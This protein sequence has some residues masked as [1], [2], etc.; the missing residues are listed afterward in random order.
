[1]NCKDNKAGLSFY[2]TRW[3]W[4]FIKIDIWFSIEDLTFIKTFASGILVPKTYKWPL[5]AKNYLEPHTSLVS[6]AHKAWLE[7]YA[8][9]FVNDFPLSFNYSYNPVVESLNYIDNGDFSIDGM[10][11]NFPMTQS[12]SIG[13]LSLF[14]S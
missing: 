6:N 7:V 2:G 11:S 9:D 12:E 3:N 5:D 4:A 8:S 14:L 10:L 1:M 13:N